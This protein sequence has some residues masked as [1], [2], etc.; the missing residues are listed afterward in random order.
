MA[1]S[2]RTMNDT[3]MDQKCGGKVVNEPSAARAK[4]AVLERL[5][6]IYGE[7]AR[8]IKQGQ[9][10]AT[11]APRTD[12]ETTSPVET[13]VFEAETDAGKVMTLV[14]SQAGQEWAIR[15]V[16]ADQDDPAREL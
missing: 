6:A 4:T 5:R 1:H 13:W 8:I 7:H 10:Y 3:A 16:T 14:A 2:L 11:S 15:K 12:V 9:M